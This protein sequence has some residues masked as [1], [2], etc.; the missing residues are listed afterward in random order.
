MLSHSS[1]A[2]S[3]KIIE[4]RNEV[5]PTSML[6][7]S[8]PSSTSNTPSAGY[9]ISDKIALGTGIE[10]GIPGLSLLHWDSIGFAEVQDDVYSSSTST[11]CS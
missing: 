4:G 9:S 8:Q 2:T 3:N 6:P 11:R 1:P 7:S 10:I 5:E